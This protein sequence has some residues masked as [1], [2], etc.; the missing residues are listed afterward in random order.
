MRSTWCTGVV[1]PSHASDC[2]GNPEHFVASLRLFSFGQGVSVEHHLDTCALICVSCRIMA[3][4]R[5]AT[6]GVLPGPSFWNQHGRVS[7]S[8]HK[9]VAEADVEVR[10]CLAGIVLIL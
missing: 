1:D 5:M 7:A 4:I 9:M 2:G 10:R 3:D 8:E 6:A